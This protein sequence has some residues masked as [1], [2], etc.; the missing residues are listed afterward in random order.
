MTGL[1]PEGG[2]IALSGD[3]YKVSV[4]EFTVPPSIVILSDSEESWYVVHLRQSA[5]HTG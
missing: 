4:T 2:G 5:I 3:E 1:R